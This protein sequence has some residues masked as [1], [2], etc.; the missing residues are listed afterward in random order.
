M[1]QCNRSRRAPAWGASLVLLLSAGGLSSCGGSSAKNAHAATD[2]GA[3]AAAT[4]TTPSPPPPNNGG[5]SATQ[6]GSTSK[7]GH[8]GNTGGANAS[9]SS[10][11]GTRAIVRA[12]SFASCMR[13]HGIKLP[14]PTRARGGATLDFKG[15]DTH[16]A[17]YKNAI[18]ACARE[19][20]GKLRLR[21][22]Q[23]IHLHGIKVG[24]VHTPSIHLGNIEV[25][26]IHVKV[27]P[28]HVTTPPLNLGGSSSGEPP[29][30]TNQGAT[31]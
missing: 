12:S 5:T 23:R 2:A 25:P 6:S 15:V 21:N 31:G 4:S 18:V 22:G 26:N 30:Q 10:P 24:G 11:S 9:S 20:L 28:I 3:S 29:T 8:T 7:Q 14:A 17:Q 1:T 13:A 19:L 27:P 16:S